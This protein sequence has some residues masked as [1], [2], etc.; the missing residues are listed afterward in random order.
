MRKAPCFNHLRS[1][2]LGFSVSSLALLSVLCAAP[3]LASAQNGGIVDPG[4]TRNWAPG[5]IAHAQQMRR[6]PDPDRGSQPTP[7]IIPKLEVDPDQSGSVGSFQPGVAT[8]TANNA[9]FQNLG[10]NGRTC[11][12]CHQPENSWSVSAASVRLRFALSGGQDPIFRLVDG[13]TCP[14]D[15][16][17]TLSAKLQA[18][19]LKV[20][21]SNPAGVANKFKDL[22]AASGALAT[23]GNGTG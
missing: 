6:F 7:P 22:G 5:A 1:S 16:V 19:K 11:F 13:A 2:L 21:G 23:G 15:T 9:F 14:S 18:Y 4:Q 17:A 3:R 20:A 12:T 10:T 8:I